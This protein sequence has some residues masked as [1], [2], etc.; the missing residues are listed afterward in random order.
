MKLSHLL[1]VALPTVALS[2]NL[3]HAVPTSKREAASCSKRGDRPQAIRILEHALPTAQQTHE[4]LYDPQTHSVLVTQMEEGRLVKLGI[5]KA[6]GELTNPVESTLLDVPHRDKEGKPFIG[7]HGLALSKMFPG[8]AWATLQYVNT[9][10]LID[11][12][13]LSV[14]ASFPCPQTLA[15]GETSIGGPHSVTEKLGHIYVTMK[16]GASCHGLPD[17]G[18]SVEEATAHGVWR[19]AI[20]EAT[21]APVDEGH[22]FMVAATP[23]MCAVDYKGDCWVVADGHPSVACIPFDATPSADDMTGSGAR[24]GEPP[25]PDDDEELR[26]KVRPIFDAVDTDGSG[27]CSVDE[28]AAIS[29]QV[30]AAAGLNPWQPAATHAPLAP[31]R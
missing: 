28:V 10:V 22:V 7:L 21:S 17:E 11:I 24:F 12:A 4:V 27:A 25:I 31:C 30:R 15:D 23:P 3:P 5:D 16:G 26:A 19:V 13:T 1:A 6:T 14:K 9:I 18:S 20:D 8:H 29:T 2:A